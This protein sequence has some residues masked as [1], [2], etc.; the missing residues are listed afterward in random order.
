M[1]TAAGFACC[2]IGEG[3]LGAHKALTRRAKAMTEIVAAAGFSSYP[4]K[5]KIYAL[6]SFYVMHFD[7]YEA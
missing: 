2:Y 4:K 6:R 5:K 3:L 1:S 7:R